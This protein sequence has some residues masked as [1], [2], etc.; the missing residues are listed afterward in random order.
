MFQRD[1][2]GCRNLGRQSWHEA[3][4]VSGQVEDTEIFKGKREVG[5]DK[6]CPLEFCLRSLQKVK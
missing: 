5:K 2:L 4:C 3:F 6:L 1:G